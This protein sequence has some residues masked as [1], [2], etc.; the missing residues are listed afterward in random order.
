MGEDG[1]PQRPEVPVGREEW[2]G[3]RLRVRGAE[4]GGDDDGIESGW[5]D[6]GVETCAPRE[7]HTFPPYVS[8]DASEDSDYLSIRWFLY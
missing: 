8:R 6:R 5:G 3:P 1:G 2:A 4:F 7:E